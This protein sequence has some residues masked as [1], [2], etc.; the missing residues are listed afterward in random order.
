MDFKVSLSYKVDVIA[1]TK[2]RSCLDHKILDHNKLKILVKENYSFSLSE[3]TL[4][5]L[6][7]SPA[8]Q[9]LLFHWQCKSFTI[10]Y[11]LFIESGNFIIHVPVRIRQSYK[12]VTK[13][14]HIQLCSID[15]KSQSWYLINSVISDRCDLG[16]LKKGVCSFLKCWQRT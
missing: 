5:S 6:R 14:D 3:N 12:I 2:C 7:S 15:Q 1:T 10:S 16:I 8:R 11:I 4:Q 13:W 9:A